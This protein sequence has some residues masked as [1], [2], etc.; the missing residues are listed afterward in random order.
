[1]KSSREVA[2]YRSYA[3]PDFLPELERGGVALSSSG[4]RLIASDRNTLIWSQHVGPETPAVLKLYRHR[5]GISWQRE[6]WFR[7]RVQREFDALAFLDAQSVPCSKPVFWSYGCDPNFGRYEILA[8]RE[9]ERAVPL[10]SILQT[11]PPAITGPALFAAYGLVRRM[12]KSGC[13]HG[14]LFGRNILVA[15]WDTQQPDAYVLDMPNAILFPY[16]ITGSQMAW[17]DLR[18]L[19]AGV[20]KYAGAEACVASLRCYGLEPEAIN[21]LMDHLQKRRLSKLAKIL[22][23]AKCEVRELLAP[24]GIWW[25]APSPGACHS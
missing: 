4:S 23:R 2:G 16:D 11:H 3:L 15:R 9:I 1:M 10:Q 24:A 22:F 19:T 21:K 12:H 8:T 13:H 25:G 6:K 20:L 14:L 5:G 7:F 18:C 17:Y